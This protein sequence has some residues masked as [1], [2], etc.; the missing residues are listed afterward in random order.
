MTVTQYMDRVVG[1]AVVHCALR[2]GRTRY[3]KRI[4]SGVRDSVESSVRWRADRVSSSPFSR[5][6]S[7]KVLC[8]CQSSATGLPNKSY[9]SKSPEREKE[10][11]ME[12]DKV[13]TAALLS[14]RRLSKSLSSSKGSRTG[15]S[16]NNKELK[17]LTL[18]QTVP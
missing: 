8:Q 17:V 1:S 2:R 12:K 13:L 11:E 4:A 3:L 7:T 14:T 6:A 15:N 10:R 16:A 5:C 9:S 18:L